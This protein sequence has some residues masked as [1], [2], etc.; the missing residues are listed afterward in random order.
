MIER[1]CYSG[2]EDYIAHLSRAL[3]AEGESVP[4]LKRK[5][6]RKRRLYNLPRSPSEEI[7]G[8]TF[9][10]SKITGCRTVTDLLLIRKKPFKYF[11]CCCNK[12]IRVK[13][14]LK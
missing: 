9:G 13:E 3:N 6:R 12:F 4:E 8:K 11:V 14:H 7:I 10:V 5:S 1:N 2:M